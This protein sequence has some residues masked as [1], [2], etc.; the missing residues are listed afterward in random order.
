L[1]NKKAAVNREA[2]VAGGRAVAEANHEE[3]E[4]NPGVAKETNRVAATL[5]L[6]GDIFR[7]TDPNRLEARLRFVKLH[8]IAVTVA[9]SQMTRVAAIAINLIILKLLTYTR[10][11]IA[12]LDTTQDGMM[13]TTTWIVPGSMDTSVAKSA[14]GIFTGSRAETGNVSGLGALILTSHPTTMTTPV[15]GT[16][17]TMI[18]CFTMIRIIPAGTSLI[19]QDWASTLTFSISGRS[20][21]PPAWRRILRA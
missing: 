2:E 14:P 11:R 4:T 5:M 17:A 21:R 12:G 1:P 9:D 10:E 15:T 3:E 6:A 16:G 13:P 19:T 18:S 7:L 8:R 20:R